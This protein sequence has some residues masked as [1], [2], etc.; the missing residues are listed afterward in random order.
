MALISTFQDLFT[1]SALNTVQWTQFTGGSATFTYG[2]SSGRW[3]GAATQVNFP[4]TTSSSTDGDLSSVASYDLTGVR[5]ML[6]VLSISGATATSSD[7]SFRLRIDGSNYLQIQ[8][9]AGTLFFQK[10][11]A[12][13]QTNIASLAFN[14]VNHAWWAFRESGGTTFWETS[15]DGF[16]FVTQTSQSN[17]IVVTSLSVL[18]AGTS[19]GVDTA[20]TPFAFRY[21]NYPLTHSPYNHAHVSD[22]M[23]RSEVMN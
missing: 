5:S 6:N 2:A 16:T 12:G 20:P 4:S 23:S 8:Y 13:V 18:I 10:V 19:F 22:G 15:N 14:A 17:P 9:E 21:F 7:C 3:A 1:G 11:V